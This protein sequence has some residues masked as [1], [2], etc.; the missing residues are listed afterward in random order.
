MR[1]TINRRIENGRATY[2]IYGA[3]AIAFQQVPTGRD[4]KPC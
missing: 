2:A 3:D 1:S 4:G